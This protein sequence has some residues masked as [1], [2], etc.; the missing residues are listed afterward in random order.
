[1]L[2]SNYIIFVVKMVPCWFLSSWSKN[3]CNWAAQ[4]I[5]GPQ[6]CGSL[7]I[8]KLTPKSWTPKNPAFPHHHGPWL[9]KCSKILRPKPSAGIMHQYIARR[10]S[11]RSSITWRHWATWKHTNCWEQTKKTATP[12]SLQVSIHES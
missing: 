3:M 2:K 5:S 7:E 11:A 1:M 9:W 10:S 12:T 6:F 4:S 8:S